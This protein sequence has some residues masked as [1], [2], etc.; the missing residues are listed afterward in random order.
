MTRNQRYVLGHLIAWGPI[1]AVALYVGF[2]KTTGREVPGYV[3]WLAVLCAV[4]FFVGLFIRD[5]PKK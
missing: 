1:L 4:T 5:T 2:F 3:G